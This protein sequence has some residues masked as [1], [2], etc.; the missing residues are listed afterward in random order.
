MKKICFI[1]IA[2]QAT[3]PSHRHIFFLSHFRKYEAIQLTFK[4]VSKHFAEVFKKLVPMGSGTLVMRRDESSVDDDEE[5]ASK[6]KTVDLFSGVGIKVLCVKT[7]GDLADLSSFS[8][9]RNQNVFVHFHSS[10]LLHRQT[11]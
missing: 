4:Q 11:S 9:P 8:F 6:S 5:G 7:V 10:G 2:T 1:R 3:Q